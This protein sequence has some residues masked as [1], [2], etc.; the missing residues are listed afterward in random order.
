MVFILQTDIHKLFV[1]NMSWQ[2]SPS[3]KYSVSG[4]YPT[5]FPCSIL[6]ACSAA[7]SSLSYS[8]QPQIP[9][10]CSL[11]SESPWAPLRQNDALVHRTLCI[12]I[13]LLI[14][15]SF[16]PYLYQGSHSHDGIGATHHN[17]WISLILKDRYQ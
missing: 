5:Y 1:R 7:Y 14:L 12:R 13:A 6:C 10:F 16:L 2:V 3:V 4:S 9:T 17:K 11:A 15:S 8:P